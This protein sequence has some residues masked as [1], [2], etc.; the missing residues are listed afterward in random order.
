MID[1]KT[2]GLLLVVGSGLSTTL[3][4]AVVLVPKLASLSSTRFLGGALA[5]SAG[6]ML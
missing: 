4:A 1:R 6:V 2:L 3:G 5:L